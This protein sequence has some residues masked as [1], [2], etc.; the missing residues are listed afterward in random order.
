MEKHQKFLE[1]NGK[2]IVFLNKDGVYMIA[3]KPILDALSLE[4]SRYLK[5]T[6]RDPFFSTY[7]D[8]MSIQVDGNGNIQAR[9]MTCLPEK[10]I[11]GWICFL[12][13]DSKELLEYKKTCY[14]LL[15]NYFHGTI[16][17]R[18]ELLVERLEI[19][20]KIHSIK[21]KLQENVQDYKELHELKQKRKRL[22]GDLNSIDTQLINQTEINFN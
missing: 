21:Q 14:D 20:T 2:T 17:G 7:L 13:G 11:Y 6:K 12:N 18:K 19:D 15:F 16:T 5:R 4:S 22:S 1:F 9:K 10:Y 3:L 8:T